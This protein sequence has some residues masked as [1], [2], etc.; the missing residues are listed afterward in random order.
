MN[1]NEKQN[2]KDIITFQRKII[3]L[4]E[5]NSSNQSFQNKS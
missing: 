4:L 1:L 2:N 3:F 5:T